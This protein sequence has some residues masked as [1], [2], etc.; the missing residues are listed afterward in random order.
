[1]TRFICRC[2][3]VSGGLYKDAHVDEAS[4]FLHY[5][6][7]LSG[8]NPCGAKAVTTPKEPSSPASLAAGDARWVEGSNNRF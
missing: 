6:E 8:W 4:L 5:P 1:M 7:E 2:I 3:Y